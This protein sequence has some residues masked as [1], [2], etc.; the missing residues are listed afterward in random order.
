MIA[1]WDAAPIAVVAREVTQM[2]VEE[3]K[4]KAKTEREKARRGWD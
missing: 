3:P 2:F 4:G 1:E